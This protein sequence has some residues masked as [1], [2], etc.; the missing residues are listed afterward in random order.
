MIDETITTTGTA[1]LR[2]Y[3]K[4]SPLVTELTEC[5]AD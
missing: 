5:V 4:L 2:P 3:I 1:L